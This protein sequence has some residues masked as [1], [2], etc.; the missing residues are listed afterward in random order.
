MIHKYS[1]MIRKYSLRKGRLEPAP[2]LCRSDCPYPERKEVIQIFTA[3]REGPKSGK[4][5]RQGYETADRYELFPHRVSMP[6]EAAFEADGRSGTPSPETT[7]F[8]KVCCGAV[9]TRD[10]DFAAVLVAMH[11]RKPGFIQ[12]NSVDVNSDVIGQRLIVALQWMTPELEECALLA[13][14]PN[15]P[16]LRMPPLASKEETTMSEGPG[17]QPDPPRPL[18]LI[19]LFHQVIGNAHLLDLV[20]LGFDPVD[21]VFLIL[22]NGIHDFP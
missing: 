2:K 21:M 4:S 18:R 12:I 13:L 19:D 6:A 16:R 14:N 1:L 7:A 5:S 10:M 22:Q 8:A 9:L 20:L 17:R 15:R 3:R 11:R